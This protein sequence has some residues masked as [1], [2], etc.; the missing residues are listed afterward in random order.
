MN[1]FPRYTSALPMCVDLPTWL[2]YLETS[3]PVIVT[4]R[5]IERNFLIVSHPILDGS[6][7]FDGLSAG[8]AR[9][10]NGKPLGVVGT[11]NAFYKNLQQNW[12]LF[13]LFKI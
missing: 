5:T 1:L 7:T 11:D 3:F 8:V 9:C 6:I 4:N 10:R 13:N 2:N 12:L